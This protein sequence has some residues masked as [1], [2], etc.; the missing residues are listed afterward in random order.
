MANSPSDWR[1]FAPS[2][3]VVDDDESTRSSF[4]RVLEEVGYFVDEAANGREAVRAVEE[5]FYEAIVMDLAMPE[6][7]GLEF[8]QTACVRLPGVRIVVVSGFMH[9]AMLTVAEHLGADTALM[10]PLAPERLLQVVHAMLDAYFKGAPSA[11]SR[12]TPRG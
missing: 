11:A 2:I 12:R 3:L 7:D 1:S 4:R 9:G 10:K 6:M 8:I 5:K